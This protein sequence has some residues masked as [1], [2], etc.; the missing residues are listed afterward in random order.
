MDVGGIEGWSIGKGHELCSLNG[1]RLREGAEYLLQK[2]FFDFV[3]ENTLC[4]K[5]TS[6]CLIVRILAIC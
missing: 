6:N 5:K 4:P 1:K 2:P 3:T